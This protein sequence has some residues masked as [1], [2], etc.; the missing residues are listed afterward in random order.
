[1]SRRGVRAL[2]LL[3]SVAFAILAGEAVCRVLDGYA[4]WPASLV[5]SRPVRAA[6]A[7][8]PAPLASRYS[9][10]V[11]LGPHVDR[12]WYAEDPPPIPPYP[13]P[14][15]ARARVAAYG[16]TNA[17]FEF[18]RA[19]L[20]DRICHDVAT[21]M[22]GAMDDFLY[23]DPV[24]PGI[25]P[26]YRHLRR[27]SAPGWFTTNAFGWRGPDLPLQKL[28]ATIRIAFVGAS[29]TVNEYAFPFS[30]PEFIGHWL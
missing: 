22:F 4:L 19:F 3:G 29:T 9:D 5:R 18:N 26:S 28:A 21:S 2:L 1:M 15:W 6:L 27:L 17:L 10:A 12:N 8:D 16:N 24:E 23:F 14:E 11:R 25:Y 13:T 7:D 30:Y 20:A